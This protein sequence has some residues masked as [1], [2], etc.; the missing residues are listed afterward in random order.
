M[1]LDKG[2]QPSTKGWLSYGY[3]L[4]DCYLL[5][6]NSA[7]HSL[8]DILQNSGSFTFQ[9]KSEACLEEAGYYNFPQLYASC[10]TRGLAVTEFNLP[11]MPNN[12]FSY[13]ITISCFNTKQLLKI[14]F[15]NI[16]SYMRVCF[17]TKLYKIS[18]GTVTTAG[19]IWCWKSATFCLL[20]K[21]PEINYEEGN[22]PVTFPT[23]R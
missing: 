5:E 23:T 18:G 10:S 11:I 4:R 1:T 17:R 22:N 19:V 8:L 7:P 2:S 21:V 12:M 16:F 15:F 20:Q 9:M 3:W 13:W 14:R 6:N